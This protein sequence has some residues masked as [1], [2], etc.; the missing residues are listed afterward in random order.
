MPA[1]LLLS[2]PDSIGEWKLLV[3]LILR[4]DVQDFSLR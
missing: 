1:G 4:D 3:G 2:L